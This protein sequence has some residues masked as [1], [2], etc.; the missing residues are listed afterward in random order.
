[1]MFI[2]SHLDSRKRWLIAG[3]ALLCI[4]LGLIFLTRPK[5]VTGLPTSDT[6][7]SASST[8]D[9]VSTSTP[10]LVIASAP[11]EGPFS[12]RV[13]IV[14]FLDFQCQGCGGYHPVLK[15]MREEFSGRIK[16]VV[17]HFPIV[18]IHQYALGAAIGSVCAQRQGKFFEYADVL[19]AN[20]QYLRRNDL[21]NYAEQMG[22][23]LA[24]FKTCLDD[25][26][27][28]AQVIADRKAG[29][30][31]GLQFTPS[32]FINGKLMQELLQ[33]DELRDLINRELTR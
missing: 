33:P 27:A 7:S 9:T 25:P 24:A 1:M 31:L 32:I 4:V 13:T 5:P 21:E 2:G 14:E 15:Q 12:A 23:D 11:T 3:F 28:Q 29:E 6:P 19:F 16:F 10:Q 30:A 8:T 20:Q 26:T 18:E 17:R 22:L